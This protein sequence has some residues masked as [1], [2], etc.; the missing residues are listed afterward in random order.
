MITTTQ[1]NPRPYRPPASLRICS[2]RSP[3]TIPS[4]PSQPSPDH[5]RSGRLDPPLID[6]PAQ[7]S[8]LRPLPA[9]PVRS[10]PVRLPK[11]CPV[12][13]V[14]TSQFPPIHP[15]STGR[16]R[17]IPRHVAP[18]HLTPTSRSRLRPNPPR[19]PAPAPTKPDYPR[20][21]PSVSPQS[22]PT[23]HAHTSSPHTG[24]TTPI[25]SLLPSPPLSH[26]HRL[27]ELYQYV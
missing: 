3:S 13:P 15:S 18:L 14:P 7:P 26:N 1:L 22:H 4:I 12:L 9:P 24:S 16:D 19:L 23:P 10:A 11:P 17:V 2:L 27:M 20:H 25:S 6:M 8:S 21:V 5:P